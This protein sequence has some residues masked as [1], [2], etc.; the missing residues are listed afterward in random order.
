MSRSNALA[1]LIIMAFLLANGPEANI[2]MITVDSE[3]EQR[4]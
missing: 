2:G 4:H 3:T 1:S